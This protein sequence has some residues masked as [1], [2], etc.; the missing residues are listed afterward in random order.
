MIL[1]GWCQSEEQEMNW[2]E[3]QLPISTAGPGVG[4]AIEE[5]EGD[6]IVPAAGPD[7]P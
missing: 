1:P 2:V 4:K 6:H 3:G 7:K 5:R